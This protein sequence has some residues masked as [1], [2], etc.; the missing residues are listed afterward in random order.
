MY[1]NADPGGGAT[2][3]R[4]IGTCCEAPCTTPSERVTREAVCM[5]K[6]PT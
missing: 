4:Q 1:P 5:P 3:W 2:R 6:Y